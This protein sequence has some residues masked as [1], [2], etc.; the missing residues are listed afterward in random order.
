MFAIF[1]SLFAAV[2]PLIL[3]GTVDTFIKPKDKYGLMLYVSLMG[4]TLFLKLYL[5]SSLCIGRI[6]WGK[7]L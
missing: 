5:N 4:I 3:Q 6:G 2:R 1:L 7:I